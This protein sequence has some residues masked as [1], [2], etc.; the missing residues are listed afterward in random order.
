MNLVELDKY[1]LSWHEKVAYLGT[2]ML[3]GEQAECPVK[4]I[5]EPGWYIRE[6][7][8]P[9]GVVFVGRPHRF[10]HE[11]EFVSGRAR[12]IGPEKDEDIW[13]HYVT[14]TTPG[15]ISVIGTLTDVVLRTYHANP[16]ECRDVEL[17]ESLIFRPAS[18]MQQV[19]ASVEKRIRSLT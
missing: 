12:L 1:G 8:I 7:E 5:F 15:H 4:H 18:E 13:C 17:M 6:M 14:F 16:D 11:L 3:K 2:Q 10:G 19:S 9:A